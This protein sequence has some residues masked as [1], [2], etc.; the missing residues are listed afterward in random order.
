MISVVVYGRNDNYGYNP[1]KRIALSLNC[2]ADQLKS[3]EDEILFV[4]YNTADEYPSAIEGMLDTL[5]TR[6]RRILRVLRVFP[7]VHRQFAAQTPFGVVEAIARN[8]GFRRSNPRNRWLLSTNTDMIFVPRDAERSLTD[9]ASEL[10]D[11]FYLLPRFEIPEAMWEGFD[12]LDPKV[13]IEDLRH[14]GRRLALNEVTRRPVVMYDAPGDFQLMLRRDL[15]R[16]DGLDE[17]MLLGNIHVDSNLCR[18]MELLRG[19]QSSLLDDLFGYHTAHTRAATFVHTR[20]NVANDYE[21]FVRGVSRAELPEQRQTWGLPAGRIEEIPISAENRRVYDF[22][23]ERTVEALPTDFDVHDHTYRLDDSLSY[24]ADHVFPYLLSA[25]APLPRNQ[26]IGFVGCR[27]DLFLRF[28]DAW[29]EMGFTGRVYGLSSEADHLLGSGGRAR[30]HRSKVKLVSE[31]DLFSYADMFLFEFGR[32][33][34]EW[35]GP[36]LAGE[37]SRWAERDLEAIVRARDVLERYVAFERAE[38]D[39]PPRRCIFIGAANNSLED[40]VTAEFD[41]TLAPFTARVRQGRLHVPLGLEERKTGFDPPAIARALRQAS[42]A[43]R[44]LPNRDIVSLVTDLKHFQGGDF[45]GRP[46][47]LAHIQLLELG[48]VRDILRID[49]E[50]L[51]R[52]LEGRRASATLGKELGAG[53]ASDTDSQAVLG[54]LADPRDWERPDWFAD[55]AQHAQGE[56]I[57]GLSRRDR[58]QWL[59]GHLLHGLT[60]L[61]VVGAGKVV[62]IVAG[63]PD[64]VWLALSSAGVACRVAATT[65]FGDRHRDGCFN[66]P[67]DRW[68]GDGLP[69][70]SLIDLDA[71]AFQEPDPVAGAADAVIILRSASQEHG[72]LTLLRYLAWASCRVIDGGVIAVAL[73]FFMGGERRGD[74]F[75]VGEFQALLGDL[76]EQAGLE[77][78]GGLDLRVSRAAVDQSALNDAMMSRSHFLRREGGMLTLPGLVFLRRTGSCDRSVWQRLAHERRALPTG[79]LSQRMRS[80]AGTRTGAAFELGAE[81]GNGIAISGPNVGLVPGSYEASLQI[82]VPPATGQRQHVATISAQQGAAV[83]ARRHVSGR[84]ARLGDIVIP[85]TVPE[86]ASVLNGRRSVEILVDHSK[87]A[88]STV[89]FGELKVAEA[90]GGAAIDLLPML[91]RGPTIAITDRGIC[92]PVQPDGHSLWGPYLS[93]PPGGYELELQIELPN[94]GPSGAGEIGLEVFGRAQYPLVPLV[95]FRPDRY[96]SAPLRLPFE[97]PGC[98]DGGFQRDG[99]SLEVRLGYPT[100]GEVLIRSLKLVPMSGG[101][102]REAIN[103]AALLAPPSEGQPSEGL[104]VTI[105]LEPGDYDFVLDAQEAEGSGP[106]SLSV[107]DNEGRSIDAKLP[108]Q[109]GGLARAEFRMPPGTTSRRLVLAETLQS[110]LRSALI[111][112]RRVDPGFRAAEPLTR[113]SDGSPEEAAVWGKEPF[114][115][116]CLVELLIPY[117]PD[118]PEGLNLHLL[119]TRSDHRVSVGLNLP[120]GKVTDIRSQGEF[121]DG[122]AQLER[123]AQGLRVTMSALSDRAPQLRLQILPAGGTLME[124]KLQPLLDAAKARLGRLSGCVHV[125]FSIWAA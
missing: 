110:Q 55:L 114:R 71:A 19:Q 98:P 75:S 62:D 79:P 31:A 96:L 45:E 22:V 36:R 25:L 70:A 120:K 93:V 16:I 115:S 34:E 1:T 112:P 52:T 82:S 100:Q 65:D 121:R 117:D 51:A 77:F 28:L 69:A 64:P 58:D 30:T 124:P 2:I 59:L 90:G 33:S 102:G 119:G 72:A 44:D 27:A 11:G 3:A 20:G 53:M 123:D 73:E 87:S 46:V 49:A 10:P 103:L 91:T 35:R 8:I 78:C 61:G 63:Q 9:I 50:A 67:R 29:R 21:T 95:S 32:R 76:V 125:P 56:S 104:A 54:K 47:L 106:S 26:S 84:E 18:R 99:E 40:L 7:S 74:L 68:L 66:P 80:S 48:P 116:Y 122:L 109:P 24:R 5:T 37:R 13:V 4:D 41:V 38:A 81:D 101:H 14:R 43:H 111:I 108:R 92:L 83:L 113:I 23:V 118:L 6:T 86:E 17:R 105:A 12:R 107:L 42:G 60:S 88:R 97:V 85:F 39:R 15:F 94:P 57:Y 89:A